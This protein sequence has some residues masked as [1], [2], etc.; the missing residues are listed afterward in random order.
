MPTHN[1]FQHY[2][3]DKISIK[4]ERGEASGSPF[5]TERHLKKCPYCL[6]WWNTTAAIMERHYLQCSKRVFYDGNTIKFHGQLQATG[7]TI[8]DGIRLDSKY[9]KQ[10]AKDVVVEAVGRLTNTPSL[11]EEDVRKIVKEEM[12]NYCG[13]TGSILS[14]QVLN[15]WADVD[16][17]LEIMGQLIQI[18]NSPGNSMYMYNGHKLEGVLP[19]G[20]MLITDGRKRCGYCNQILPKQ[21]NVKENGDYIDI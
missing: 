11:T 2:M 1:L 20:W 18:G 19:Q 6:E 8:E 4:V 10:L 17:T 3:D 9:I 21:I 12:E 14:P 15:D 5:Y 13:K 7:L 16:E